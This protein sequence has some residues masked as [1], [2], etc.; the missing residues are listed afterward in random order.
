MTI[1][2]IETR[3]YGCRFRSRLEAKWA[4]F[5]T[6][7]GL[8]W[9]HEPE[10]FNLGTEMYLPDF[11]V[12]SGQLTYWYEIKPRG[13]S[14]CKKFAR[15]ADL[16]TQGG[17]SWNTEARLVAGDPF[18]VFIGHDL[19]PRCG[20]YVDAEPFDDEVGFLCYHCDLVTE[21][22]G[23]NPTEVGFAGVEFWPHKGWIM[24][25]SEDH[26]LM[27]SRLERACIAARSARFEH[28]EAP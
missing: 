7:L 3:A 17:S 12:K 1:T 24:I 11:R 21:S 18:D 4:V 26:R 2:P 15:F 19:C 14:L 25:S 10:G 20:E 5:F 27:H 6:E 16:V 8:Q 13:S 28:G 23:G 9:E 22:G